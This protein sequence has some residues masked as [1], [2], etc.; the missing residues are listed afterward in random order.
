MSRPEP[1]SVDKA[2][3][4]AISEARSAAL[5]A[6]V[7]LHRP[8]DEEE[9]SQQSG[10]KVSLSFE[11]EGLDNA[12]SLMAVERALEHIP[13]VSATL[14]YP[15]QTAWITATE[16]ID[17]DTIIGVFE[18]FGIRAY[19]SN[20]SL[21]RRHQQLSAEISREARV[22]RYQFRRA[23]KR[24]S[25]R[26]R[27]HNREEMMQALRARE[28]G[29]IKRKKKT[30]TLNDDAMSGDVLF[31]ARALIT[32]MRF[33]V[34]LPFAL[35]V[36]L[37]SFNPSLQ[38]D[39]WQ[40]L[41]ALLSIPV[42]MWGAWPFHRAAAG[43]IR[44]GISALD[45][46]SSVAIA[47][48]YLWS[49]AMLFF[50]T[51]G[52]KSWRSYPAWFAFDHGTLT[53]NEIYFDVA[54][55]ITVLLLAGRLLTRKRSQSSLL[56]ELDRLQIDPH[57]VVTV[58][59]KHRATRKVIELNI[60]IMEVRVNDDIMI[61][62]G[63][64]IP[65]DGVVIGGGSSIAASIIMGQDNH[66]VKVNDKVFAGSL[67]ITEEIKVRVIR[68]GHRTRIA[69]VHRWVKEATVKENRHNRAAIHSAGTLVP[70][71]FTLAV[72]NFCL[73]ALISG[74]IN[75]AFTTALAVLACV[76][77]VALALSAPLA[78]RNSV[79]AAARHG[80]L[81]RSGEILRVLDD[82]DTVVFNRLGTLT[83]GEMT[84][85]TVTADKGEDPE[86][87]LRVAGALAME[88]NHSI[89][90]AL[91]KASREARD[92][93]TGGED[94]P[95]WIDVGAVEITE[96][97]A[98]Q[99]KIELPYINS[100]GEKSMRTVDA[101]LWRPRSMSEVREH[102][103]PRLIAAAT[104]GGAPL[105]IRWK[106]KDR[107]VITLNDHV[108]PDA[109]EAVSALEDQGIETM[110]LSRDTYPVARRYADNLGIT[111]VLAGIAPGKKPHV[112]RSV[113]T[114]GS[115]VAM[116][117]DG[118]VLDSMKVA[119]VGIL[120]GVNSHSE[121]RDDTDDPAADVVVLRDEVASVPFLFRLARRYVK[122]VNGN[123]ALSWIY[124]GVAMVLAISGLLH[125]MAATV[126]MLASSLII[127][128]RS[129]R[130]RRF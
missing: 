1:S 26:V 35:V 108:R 91:V 47:A 33:W 55:G 88:S 63:T 118:S 121:L 87:V 54:C 99:A 96:E 14:I 92:S 32:P 89:S 102:L 20:S 11:L 6:G 90:K 94:V 76:A 48:A 103:S 110:M 78:T 82:V 19:L 123:I 29:W 66:D 16:K 101:L 67:N 85:E 111:H 42:V 74:N 126:A 34:C 46:T 44:R 17:L 68:T 9:D 27:R 38:F 116:V 98:F 49:L 97:G 4:A 31:T 125:P 50:E 113:H 127:E 105:I 21:M 22:E 79:E 60:P 18:R 128:W 77:P 81:V 122:L 107:G 13:G 65:V 28:S 5:K 53:Q 56:A 36:V 120:M 106:G 114:R 25:P 124:N 84:V 23:S 75:A 15:T 39:Y 100:S 129:G 95:H 59:R 58:V 69:A 37:L 40:W 80:I 57:Q 130:A 119:D 72:V 41:S 104:S 8:V 3:G 10:I 24:M 61:P 12:P 83:D 115:T 93:G 7:G 2:V 51:P 70:I 62:P 112:V 73:W 86:L 64:I 30:T 43:G 109:A 117:G 45:A 52:N 71:T